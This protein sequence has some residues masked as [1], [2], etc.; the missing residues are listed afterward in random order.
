MRNPILFIASCIFFTASYHAA[1]QQPWPV[2]APLAEHMN[3]DS[4]LSFDKDISNGKYG[5]ID[6]MIITRNG[7]LIYQKL[8]KHNYDSIYGRSAG[9]KSALNAHDP[10]GQYNYYNPWW[11]PYYK[12]DKL[13]SLQSVSKTITSVIIGVAV[14]RNEFPALSTTV[15]SFFD[16]SQVKNIDERKRKLTIRHL[17]TMTDGLEWNEGRLSYDDPNNDCCIMEAGYDWVQYVINKPTMQEPGSTFNY[18]SGATQLLSYIFRKATGKDI[19]EY[20]AQYLFAPLGIQEYFWK[21]IPTGLAD[22]EGGLYLS[23]TD[24]AKIFYL[25]LQNGQWNGRQLVSAEWV[26]ASVTPSINVGRGASYGYKWW[27]FEYGNGKYAWC[28][29]GFGGQFPV[30][31]PEYGIVA[32]FN[33][34]N[35]SQGRRSLGTNEIIR[36]I[37]GAVENK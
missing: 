26:K 24:L 34:W 20:A 2:S 37:T 33:G 32:V 29:N 28:G 8:W 9:E 7:K 19:E 15:L 31:I 13:H 30:I 14:T 6:A 17:L 12:R 5:F 27:L 21:R 4:L 36:R 23:A 25:F 18:N 10:G 16:T 35:I 22:T 11:H 1:A 3:N